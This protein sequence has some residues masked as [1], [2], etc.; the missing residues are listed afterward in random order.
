MQS[1]D[2]PENAIEVCVQILD[3]IERGLG[4]CEIDKRV[5]QKIAGDI[6]VSSRQLKRV[7]RQGLVSRQESILVGTVPPRDE[8]QWK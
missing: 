1:G 8:P 5:L 7:L 4:F 6:A 2:A 3:L